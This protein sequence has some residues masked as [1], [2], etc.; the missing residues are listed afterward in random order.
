MGNEEQTTKIATYLSQ[1]HVATYYLLNYLLT[2]LLACLR[3]YLLTPWCRIS[4]ENLI[5]T[6]LVKKI[7][8]S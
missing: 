6:Q 3:T 8:L 5:V 1:A 4:F 7:P 2:Y